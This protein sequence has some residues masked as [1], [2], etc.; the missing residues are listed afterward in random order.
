MH[1]LRL[2]LAKNIKPSSRGELE[3]TSINNEYLRRNKL[4]VELMGRGITWLDTGTH[5][6][7]LQA[8][9]FVETIQNRQG[10]YIACI[11]EI[12]YRR[13]FIT[14]EQVIELAKPLL[15]NDYGKYLM[16]IVNM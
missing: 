10:L 13:G 1:F 12:A 2:H 15:K 4:K 7:L 5:K 3:I 11:E 6:T 14:K 16:K 8:A 9:N